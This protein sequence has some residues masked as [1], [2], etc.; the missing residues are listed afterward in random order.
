MS[1]RKAARTLFA[2]TVTGIATFVFVVVF[3]H[4]SQ[5]DYDPRSQMMSELALGKS[6]DLLLVA[7][8]G[9]S[10]AI[11]TT[12]V[13]L[14]KQGSPAFLTA[15]L[16]LA[17]ACF[18]AAGI[19]TLSVSAESHVLFVAIGFIACG[20][21]MYLLPRTS[22]AFSGL[23]CHIVSWGSCLVMSVATGAGGN[24]IMAGVAQR[25]SPVALLLWLSYVAGTLA[26]T[27]QP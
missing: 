15:L 27:K 23:R 26:L 3:L 20:L 2:I 25:I 1:L 16:C 4:L 7:F 22:L 14:L 11:G 21:S 19:V 24:L 8:I 13:S 9:L 6:G 17:S 5:P 12:A 18:L 10:V